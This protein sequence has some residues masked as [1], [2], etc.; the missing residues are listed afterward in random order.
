M[1]AQRSGSPGVGAG[2]RRGQGEEVGEDSEAA[3]ADEVGR[4]VA[5]EAEPLVEAP[6]GAHVLGRMQ[7]LRG[8]GWCVGQSSGTSEA[9]CI[10]QIRVGHGALSLANAFWHKQRGSFEAKGMREM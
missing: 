1:A 7:R 5:A 4:A 6:R 8:T 9:G 10:W 3:G 2:G